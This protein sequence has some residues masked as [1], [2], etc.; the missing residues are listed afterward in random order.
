[1][2]IFIYRTFILDLYYIFTRLTIQVIYINVAIA[3]VAHIYD[4]VY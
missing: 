2:F 1:M 3:D 4:A